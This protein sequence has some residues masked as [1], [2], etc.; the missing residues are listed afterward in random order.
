MSPIEL[1]KK[2]I[3][4][5]F[6]C[7]GYT[8]VKNRV[9]ENPVYE[10]IL[11]GATYAPWNKDHSFLEIFNSVKS[12]T[13][14]DKYRCY[15]LWDLVKNVTKVPGNLI[16]VGVWRGGSGAIIAKSSELCGI[17]SKVYLCDTFSGVPKASGKDNKYIGG[18][19]SDTSR[20]I[21]D[22]L[23]AKLHLSNVLILP[24]IFPDETGCLIENQKF[25]F[26]HIDVDVYESAKGIVK[27]IWNRLS[28]GGVIVFDDYGIETTNGITTYV[29]EM[30]HTYNCVIIY[31]LNGHAII[32]KTGM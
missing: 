15:E 12:N 28:I 2:V 32:I 21:V 24:G 22:S 23:L 19:H 6:N 17:E 14:V 16:E 9:S 13:L 3:I 7:L 26:C 10:L 30:D 25:R 20:E 11:T 4:K 31:N 27:W 8:I 29:N 18:E 5:S 1:I